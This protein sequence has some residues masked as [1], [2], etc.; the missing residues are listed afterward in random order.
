MEIQLKRIPASLLE[1]AEF[2]AKKDGYGDKLDWLQDVALKLI[3]RRLA[4]DTDLTPK[5]ARAQ[6][7]LGKTAFEKLMAAGEFPGL[8]MVNARVYRIPQADVDRYKA[9]HTRAIKVA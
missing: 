4:G 1:R 9:R 2:L 7:K 6:L 5:E 8:Y 3:E